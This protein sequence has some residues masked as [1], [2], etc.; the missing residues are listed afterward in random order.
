MT[1]VQFGQSCAYLAHGLVYNFQL[2]QTTCFFPDHGSRLKTSRER[3]WIPAEQVEG[4]VRGWL[5]F[6]I[7]FAFARCHLEGQVFPFFFLYCGAATRMNHPL[8]SAG[9]FK[10]SDI[11]GIFTSRIFTSSAVSDHNRR[12]RPFILDEPSQAWNAGKFREG[13]ELVI[14]LGG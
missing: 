4:K 14:H 8:F 12:N 6:W 11:F 10:S 9:I 3:P 2:L 7:R 5:K 1:K 13:V